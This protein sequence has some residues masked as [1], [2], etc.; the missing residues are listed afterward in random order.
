FVSATV[1]IRRRTL[2][3]YTTLFRSRVAVDRDAGGVEE[4]LGL[5]AVEAG[6]AQVDE[7]EVDVGTAGD[8]GDAGLADGGLHEP[9]GDD[10]GALEGAA[11]PVG[12]LLAGGN[13]ER[14]GL[15][16][17]DVHERAALLAGE[18]RGVELLARV[19]G[20]AGQDQARARA[21][22]GFVD[23]RGDDVGVR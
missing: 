2:F 4:V 18:D 23:G 19:L 22:E 15:G 20:V 21:A 5:L 3:P 1:A 12:E 10:P 13:L 16:G 6:V 17:D 11:L 7:D 9:L 14:H 8:D